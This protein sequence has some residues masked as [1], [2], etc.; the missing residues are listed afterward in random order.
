LPLDAR[1]NSEAMRVAKTTLRL[2]S[3]ECMVYLYEAPPEYFGPYSSLRS[4]AIV[5]FYDAAGNSCQRYL[6]GRLKVQLALTLS[7]GRFARLFAKPP[8][9]VS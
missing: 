6:N 9:E 1:Y 8:R 4:E 3:R 5:S 2:E 7:T